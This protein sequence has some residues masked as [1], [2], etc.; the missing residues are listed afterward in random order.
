MANIAFSAI[1]E[2]LDKITQN[3]TNALIGN[4]SR[5]G[6]LLLHGKEIAHLTYLGLRF[7]KANLKLP[8]YVLPQHTLQK[9][10]ETTN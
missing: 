10:I 8:L 9:F 5:R 1:D 3:F 6:L 7:R 2:K 4:T